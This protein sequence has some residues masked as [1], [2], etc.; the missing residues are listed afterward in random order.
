MP[1]LV[2]VWRRAR[3]RVKAPTAK[4][5][6]AERLAQVKTTVRVGPAAARGVVFPLCV[7]DAAIAACASLPFLTLHL[8]A[9]GEADTEIA[10]LA[11]HSRA[12]AVLSNDSDFLVC[13]GPG[14]VL[15]GSLCVT[16]TEA[17]GMLCTSR[18]IATALKLAPCALPTLAC[19]AGND[20]VCVPEWALSAL[21]YA[22]STSSGKRVGVPVCV[23][24]SVCSPSLRGSCARC[25]GF[26]CCSCATCMQ[27]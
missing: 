20:T 6:T 2:L 7:I 14:L 27:L 22:L 5:R 4:S 17:T 1:L 13:S 25:S 9:S 10:R 19:L 8:S 15:F 11:V 16:P 12:H 21:A 3:E 18:I 24:L 26:C 23:R